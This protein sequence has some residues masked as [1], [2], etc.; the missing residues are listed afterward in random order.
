MHLFILASDKGLSLRWADIN[1]GYIEK[2]EGHNLKYLQL[3]KN[4]NSFCNKTSG[5]FSDWC[6]FNINT[7][8][9][10]SGM[11]RN[12]FKTLYWWRNK[13]FG[14]AYLFIN[15]KLRSD[16]RR[17]PQFEANIELFIIPLISCVHRIRGK[18]AQNNSNMYTQWFNELWLCGIFAVID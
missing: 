16:W 12:Y 14:N 2:L 6:G 13:C 11:G 9:E 3:K 7:A 1:K 5:L 10:L 18:S 15:R 17:W 4:R 8:S